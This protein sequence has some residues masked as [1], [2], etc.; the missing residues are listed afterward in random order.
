MRI[1]T[2][3]VVLLSIVAVTA[4]GQQPTRVSGLVLADDSGDPLANARV[5]LT[6]PNQGRA[7]LTDRD[8]RFVLALSSPP[9][10]V[11]V[12]ASKT[13]YG[14][15]EVTAA[16][17]ET[18]EVRLAR[19]AAISGR[20]VDAR[21]DP[22]MNARVV[23][24]TAAS[25]T[26]A[27]VPG[28]AATVTDDR[29][30]YR[31]G[32]LAAGTFK[33]AVITMGTPTRRDMPGGG[34]AILPSP[35]KTYYPD[36]ATPDTA[37]V[38]RLTPGEDRP[39]IDFA[40]FNG[41]PGMAQM[42]MMTMPLGFATPP[43]PSARPTAVVR[44]RVVTTDA[45]AVPRADVRLMPTAPAPT[46]PGAPA[47][48]RPVQPLIVTADDD[49]RFEFVD[50]A[51]GSYR[52]AAMKMGYSPPGESIVFGPP[53]PMSGLAID[54][55]DGQ[56]RERADITLARWGSL[57]GRVVDEL[58][59]PMQGVSV[60][61]LQVR[62]QAARRRLVAAAGASRVTDDRGRFRTYGVAPGQYI[63]SATVGDTA[64]ADLPGYT[65]SYY[66]GTA[67][68][69]EAQ[70]VSIGVS[71]DMSGIELSMAR[72]RTALVSG[73][74]LDAA[75]QPTMGGSL[76]LMPSQRSDAAAAVPMGARITPDGRF[77][78]GNVSPG[79]YVIQADRGRRNASTDG[80]F[81]TL[82]VAVDG[83]DVTN[84]VLQ[85]SAGSSITGSVRF[86]SYQG[87]KIPTPG[88]IDILPAPVDPDQ[89]PANPAFAAIHDDWTF[90][91]SGVNGPRR[92]QV[93]R[94]PAEWA[95]KE[96]RV[97]GIDVTDRPLAFGRANQSLA[98]VEVVLTD[99]ITEVIGTIV[100]DQGR[101]APDAHVVIFATDRDRWYPA[102]RFLRLAAAGADGAIDIK[103][104]PPGSYYAT[105]VARLPADGD[106]A[107]Q[108]PAYLET[109]VAHATAF[110]LG[111]G[112][113]QGLSLKLP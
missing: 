66:P 5:I 84:L 91:V 98:D 106:G 39:S 100:D 61:L 37:E 58:G 1:S 24:E 72:T 28:A 35:I 6:S 108:D 25:S 51:A 63:V 48:A 83:A 36:A 4:A 103:S 73:T 56:T 22:V 62:Y 9:A 21:G 89:S 53:A 3:A 13:G 75:G 86:D 14:R 95:F 97:R 41:Q 34:V 49:G 45:R 19:G 113:K 17:G 8:G 27:P 109:L 80:E 67:N 46:A 101:P 26:G 112:Q 87:A 111:M 74:L 96:I 78:F 110:A 64:S 59:D 99:Q 29:G 23:A 54:L 104:L 47:A 32:S 81:G 2:P 65:R 10:R 31:I 18:I 38:I 92:L 50:L 69:G 77:E 70:F 20:V 76:K 82:A 11:T 42:M 71:Q 68:A 107:W 15:R 94:A 44:G 12:A 57:T 30:E 60:Q 85:M 102:S 105:V 55:T 7:V 88:A 93:T 52:I 33:V 43:V 16:M 90:E 40:V 79:Q